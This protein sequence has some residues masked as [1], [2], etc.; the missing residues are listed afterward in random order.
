MLWDFVRI[1]KKIEERRTNISWVIRIK[2][3]DCYSYLI[4]EYCRFVLLAFNLNPFE[5]N[6]QSPVRENV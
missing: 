4:T 6:H 5:E 1:S 3:D 2:L